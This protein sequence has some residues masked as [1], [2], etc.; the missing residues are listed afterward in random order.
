MTNWKTLTPVG[1]C[2]IVKE[3]TPEAKSE[4]GILLPDSAQEQPPEGEVLG[5]GPH[6][7]EPDD[8]GDIL[9]EFGLGEHVVF[10]PHAG[11]KV[12]MDGG[13]VVK[14][15]RVKDIIAVRRK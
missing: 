1:D 5:I 13:D 11:A 2:V 15:M 6:A 8:D 10:L 12:T 3:I 7:W 14:V 4:G 9:P